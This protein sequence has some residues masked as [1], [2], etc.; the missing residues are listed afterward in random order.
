MGCVCLFGFVGRSAL[1][2]VWME[3]NG[4]DWGFVGRVLYKGALA[5]IKKASW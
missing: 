5:G 4:G 2:V 3:V 1:L